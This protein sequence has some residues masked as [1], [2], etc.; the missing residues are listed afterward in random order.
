[1]AWVPLLDAL[2][3]CWIAGRSAWWLLLFVVLGLLNKTIGVA[4]VLIFELI[5]CIGIAEARG[6][7]VWVGLLLF[8]PFV[9][10]FVLGY[11]AFADGQ[12]S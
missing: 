7:S 4:S 10:L 11:L 1:M 9:N 5:L 3:V 2:P 8:L 12:T 6:K